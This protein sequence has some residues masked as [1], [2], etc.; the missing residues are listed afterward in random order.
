MGNSDVSNLWTKPHVTKRILYFTFDE[1]HCVSQWNKFRKEYQHLGDLRYLIPETIP[2][3][4]ASATLP[5]AILLD[6]VE[7][8]RLRSDKTEHIIRSNDR[9]DVHLMVREL[10]FPAS[11]F[12]DLEFLIVKGYKEGDPPIP[13]FLI[14]FDNTKE[15]ERACHH[16]RTLL[17]PSLQSRIKYF[18]STMTQAYRDEVLEEMRDSSTWGLCCTDAFGMVG[19]STT[20][21]NS[22]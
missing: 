8:L 1:G 13:K 6:V 4:V 12:K 14:F 22:S 9:S 15:A 17:P 11:S 5:P 2:F 7:I 10:V 18:H 16:L 21:A 20:I 3:Y 19:I